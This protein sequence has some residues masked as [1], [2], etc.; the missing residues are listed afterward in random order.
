[1]NGKYLKNVITKTW[2]QPN[3]AHPPR[4]SPRTHPPTHVC[5]CS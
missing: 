4:P 2:E 1:M 5:I 3:Q